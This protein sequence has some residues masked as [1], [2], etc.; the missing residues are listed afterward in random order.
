MPSPKHVLMHFRS[1]IVESPGR[2]TN[3]QYGQR[4]DPAHKFLLWTRTESKFHGFIGLCRTPTKRDWVRPKPRKWKWYETDVE[5]RWRPGRQRKVLVWPTESSCKVVEFV[6]SKYYSREEREESQVGL[7][8]VWCKRR[9]VITS[10]NR[11]AI[12]IPQLGAPLC[13]CNKKSGSK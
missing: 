4:K 3:R 1:H 12:T 13:N 10:R 9:R 11:A 2:I 8:C 5:P 6:R 7:I